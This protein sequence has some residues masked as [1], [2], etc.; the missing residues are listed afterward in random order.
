MTL[1]DHDFLE[2]VAILVK[3]KKHAAIAVTCRSGARSM[4]G[5]KKLVADGYTNVANVAG[6]FLEWEKQHLPLDRP[7]F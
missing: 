3:H 6:G 1:Q 4:L 5:A 2:R 7:P